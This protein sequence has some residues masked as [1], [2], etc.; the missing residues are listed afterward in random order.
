M[1]T[2]WSLF[3]KTTFRNETLV[4][5]EDFLKSGFECLDKLAKRD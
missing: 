5:K 3:V 4:K 1:F 2:R